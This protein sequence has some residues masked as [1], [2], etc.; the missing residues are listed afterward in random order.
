MITIIALLE[1]CY[2]SGQL[3]AFISEDEE[4]FFDRVTHALQVLTMLKA[5]I[6]SEGYIEMKGED[7][8]NRRCTVITSL[9][10]VVIDY[11][12]GL[13]QG[14]TPSVLNC[15]LVS[16]IKIGQW[17]LYDAKNPIPHRGGFFFVC[18]DEFDLQHGRIANVQKQSY[19]D[20]AA[21]F[22]ASNES[23]QLD[24]KQRHER[25]FST[26]PEEVAERHNCTFELIQSS[27]SM[28]Q[29]TGNAS[30]AYKLPRHGN[31]SNISLANVDQ[32]IAHE[33]PAHVKTFEYS[34]QKAKPK[35]SDMP[36]NI[37]LKQTIS[38][39]DE[40]E[41]IHTP[42]TRITNTPQTILGTSFTLDGD[43]SHTG[44]RII[45]KT[46]KKLREVPIPQGASP[47]AAKNIANTYVTP[48][49]EWAHLTCKISITDT[50][51]LDRTLTSRMRPYARLGKHDSAINLF[52]P[53]SKHGLGLFSFTEKRLTS[54]A[55][56]LEVGLHERTDH[57]C[58]L[59]SCNK[60]SRELEPE[61]EPEYRRFLPFD[62]NLLA[63]YGYFVRDSYR[64][65]ESLTLDGLIKQV[66][67]RAPMHNTP[68]Q[69]QPVG[70]L[71]FNGT[72]RFSSPYIGAGDSRLAAGLIVPWCRHAVQ[73]T[74]PQAAA[75][76]R[77]T[78]VFP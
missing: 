53:T 51:A 61:Q 19:S 23:K 24:F 16:T 76:D 12:V 31:K 9:G 28:V 54:L 5:G 25:N 67:Q 8:S 72:A 3:I 27:S 15:N 69:L 4:K 58:A 39:N 35:T 13:P 40:D 48:A 78:V 10:E 14:Q 77:T 62:L 33:L 52:H 21:A 59:R 70:H 60:L 34:F 56:E 44:K 63:N 45:Q 36:V 74:K 75:S 22:I 29:M 71:H 65:L 38:M 73:R 20:D 64:L 26:D 43:S 41:H 68:S 66:N 55:R 18:K 17:T 6:P 30:V 47:S 11:K 7:M 1:E 32:E 42:S 57:G 2:V 46:Q 49:L 50:D 37:S